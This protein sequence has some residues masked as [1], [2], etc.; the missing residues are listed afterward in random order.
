MPTVQLLSGLG[1]LVQWEGVPSGHYMLECCRHNSSSWVVVG[2][3]PVQGLSHVVEG[4]DPGDKYIFRVNAGPSSI[5]I[6]IQPKTGNS[7]WE[8]EQFRRRYVELEEMGHGRFCVVKRARDR[9]TGQEVAVKQVVC[10]KQSHEVTQAEYTLL[11]Q[12]QHANIVRALAL[13]NS[14]PQTGMDSIVM[15]L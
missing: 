2:G 1:V 7:S 4:L 12:L 6:I 15:E 10:K 3:G 11:A 13:F 5:P 8:E 14:A 9:G